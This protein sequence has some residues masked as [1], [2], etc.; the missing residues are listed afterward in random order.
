MLINFVLADP[1][2]TM[3]A[4]PKTDIKLAL[5]WLHDPRNRDFSNIRPS[6][7][8]DLCGWAK[9]SNVILDVSGLTRTQLRELFGELCEE[10][11]GHPQALFGPDSRGLQEE[12]REYIVPVTRRVCA[13]ILRATDVPWKDEMGT[14]LF[15]ALKELA[16]YRISRW[17]MQQKC[18][19]RRSLDSQRPS[20]SGLIRPDSASRAMDQ[21]QPRSN[22]LRNS[23]DT[24]NW[25]GGAEKSRQS[26]AFL[27][28]APYE[29]SDQEIEP[30]VLS[31]SLASRPWSKGYRHYLSGRPRG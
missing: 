3:I 9:M 14:W 16:P 21:I 8:E 22:G 10:E 19:L 7:I 13:T 26:I 31:T 20:S 4:F 24:V 23:F 17:I 1:E 30:E 28:N 25:L 2:A 6:S 11:I 18:D 5:Y 29:S 27:L 15:G 12:Y